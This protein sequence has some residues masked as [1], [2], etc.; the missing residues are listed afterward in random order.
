VLAAVRGIAE[1][2]GKKKINALDQRSLFVHHVQK[3]GGGKGAKGD[4]ISIKRKG[5]WGRSPEQS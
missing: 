5:R 2:G 3:G 4:G 1:K